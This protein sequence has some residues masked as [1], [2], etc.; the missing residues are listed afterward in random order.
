MKRCFIFFVAFLFVFSLTLA[1][2]QSFADS[3]PRQIPFPEYYLDECP[4]KGTVQTLS[5]EGVRDV[6]VYTPYG[7]DPSKQYDVV[8]LLHGSGGDITDWITKSQNVFSRRDRVGISGRKLYDWMIYEG[9]IKPVIIASID[10]NYQ[11]TYKE[12]ETDVNNVIKAIVDNFSTFAPSFSDE[13]IT[14]ARKHFTIGGLSMGSM[15]LMRYMLDYPDFFGNYLLISGYSNIAGFQ[16]ELAE[17]ENKPEKIFI[18]C[19]ADDWFIM[20]ARRINEFMP[21]CSDD[22]KLVEYAYGHNWRTWFSS[23]YD[24]LIYLYGT[25]NEHG[26][27][28]SGAKSIIKRICSIY[29]TTL[30]S[31]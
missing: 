25:D 27:F 16:K 5:M 10:N 8:L 1:P 14:N 2:S 4:V 15:F 26:D 6:C 9:K 20:Y 13:N 30:I 29:S 12:L 18:G 21:Q 17:I 11:N 7:Y 24:S 22:V 23:I 28:Q 19:G 3:E 31:Q